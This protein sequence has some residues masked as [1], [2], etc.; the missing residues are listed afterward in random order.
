MKAYRQPIF[1]FGSATALLL[2]IAALSGKHRAGIGQEWMTRANGIF[3]Y[4]HYGLS[5]IGTIVLLVLQA[6][7]T[8]GSFESFRLRNPTAAGRVQGFGRLAAVL[9]ALMI[10]VL[11][12]LMPVA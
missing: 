1:I 5:C 11:L 7:F 12:A 8:S 4:T 10:I 3:W 2:G 9:T 6:Y